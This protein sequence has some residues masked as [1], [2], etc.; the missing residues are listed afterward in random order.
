MGEHMARRR[1]ARVIEGSL[2]GNITAV[3]VELLHR[4]IEPLLVGGVEYIVIDTTG[5]SDF[6]PQ[7]R[8]PGVA[9]LAALKTAR[10]KALVAVA[11]NPMV[12]MMGSALGLAASM[13]MVFVKDLEEADKVVAKEA[14]K[15]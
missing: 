10:V 6:S 4:A 12:R 1:D 8:V 7:V 3:D 9:F 13:R 14:A 5:I 11:P 2:S 15:K